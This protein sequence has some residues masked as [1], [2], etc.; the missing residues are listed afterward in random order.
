MTGTAY[1][2]GKGA[3]P[4]KKAGNRKAHPAIALL[5]TGAGVP[6]NT[7]PIYPEVHQGHSR[8]YYKDA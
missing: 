7:R 5:Q 8:F 6:R 2:R 4:A 3:L 1:K